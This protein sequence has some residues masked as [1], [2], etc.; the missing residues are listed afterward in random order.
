MHIIFQTNCTS[1]HFSSAYGRS[2]GRQAPESAD[3]AN[4]KNPSRSNSGGPVTRKPPVPR[5]SYIT[6]FTVATTFSV[7]I[8]NF[9]KRT[10]A[11][12]L[13]PNPCMVT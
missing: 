13:A 11:G 5:D 10:A 6:D 9:L 1:A 8:P 2:P 12:A 4:Q 3:P 7:V